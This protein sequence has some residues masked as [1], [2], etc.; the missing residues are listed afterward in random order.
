MKIKM[1]SLKDLF[2]G[3]FGLLAGLF[4]LSTLGVLIWHIWGWISTGVWTNHVLA[5]FVTQLSS[6][7]PSSGW[8]Y[9]VVA[10]QVLGQLPLFLLFGFLAI[11]C[12][13]LNKVFG[14]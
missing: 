14:G 5:E 2:G 6:T 1:D 7:A 8:I 11:A 10:L 3:V 9:G 4:W 13:G 12:N